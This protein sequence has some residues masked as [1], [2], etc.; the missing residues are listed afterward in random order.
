MGFRGD[1][2]FNSTGGRGG[3]IEP[4]LWVRGEAVETR[5]TGDPLSDS[6]GV[7]D[8]FE[9]LEQGGVTPDGPGESVP[10]TPPPNS[11]IPFL[12]PVPPGTDPPYVRQT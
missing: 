4:S 5:S 12:D 9:S 3:G 11:R 1:S 10:I 8:T 7:G 2:T 6:R